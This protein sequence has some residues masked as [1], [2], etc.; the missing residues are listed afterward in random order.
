[1]LS[2]LLLA[3]PVRELAVVLL[4]EPEEEVNGVLGHVD[5]GF[6]AVAE[7]GPGTLMSAFV[8]VST[9]LDLRGLS[10]LY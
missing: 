7:L 8:S 3:R 10:A 4:Q 2:E 6:D 5:H 9:R 1:M